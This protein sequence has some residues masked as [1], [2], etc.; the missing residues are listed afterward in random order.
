MKLLELIRIEVA[1]LKTYL[2]LGRL[3]TKEQIKVIIKKELNSKL[4]IQNNKIKYI[5]NCILMAF[6]RPAF[7]QKAHCF[8]SEINLLHNVNF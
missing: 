2:K 7:L 4:Q 6:F 5:L 1:I 8:I 3:Q